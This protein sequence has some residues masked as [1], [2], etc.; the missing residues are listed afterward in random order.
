MIELKNITKKYNERTILD[1]ISLTIHPGQITFIVGT[2]GAGK[3]TLLNLIGGL[4][5][6]TSGD[7]LFNGTSIQKDLNT[8]RAKNIGFVFQDFN[9]FSQY[10]SLGGRL[11]YV[12]NGRVYTF[13]GSVFTYNALGVSALDAAYLALREFLRGVGLN[14]RDSV[15]EGFDREEFSSLLTDYYDAELRVNDNINK[16]I[17]RQIDDAKA[18]ILADIASFEGAIN[19]TIEEMQDVLDNTIETWF[20]SGVPSLST[21][22][23]SGWTS[24]EYEDHLGDLYY[25]DD[26]GNGY[27][28]QYDD[29]NQVYFWNLLQDT[30]ATAALALARQAKDTADGKRRVFLSQPTDAQAYDEGDLWLHATIGVYSDETLVCLTAKAAGVAFNAGDWTAATKYTDDTV[31]NAAQSAATAAQTT[32][33]NAATAASRAQTAADNAATAASTVSTRLDNWASDGYV[34]PTEKAALKQQKNE[35]DADYAEIIAD[36]TRYA[37][38]TT[39]FVSAYN[40]AVTA[41]NKYTAATPELIPVTAD[42]A[43]IAAYYTA[44]TTILE[45]IATAAKKV[46]TDA[47]AAADAAQTTATNAGSAA[48]AAQTTANNAASAAATA[49]S[50]ANAAKSIAEAARDKLATWGSD[51]YISPTEKTA[52]AQQY[53]D[54]QTERD[55]IVAQATSYSVST[56]SYLSAYTNAIAAFQKY[57]AASPESIAVDTDYADIAAYYDARTLIL[58]AISVAAKTVA[59]NAQ[60]AADNAAS[61]AREAKTAAEEVA[62]QL[63]KID[64]DAVLD[65]SE[66]EAIRTTWTSINGIVST[67]AMG[68]TGT[69]YAAKQMIESAAHTGFQVKYS[70]NNKI[71]TYRGAYDEDTQTY[72]RLI[73]TRNN[74]GEGALDAAYYALREYLASVQ[75]N[76]D[77]AFVGFDRSVYA[78][79]LRDYNVA[80]NNVMKVL[81]ELAQQTAEK[82]QDT[83][84]R[85]LVDATA[86]VEQLTAWGADGAIS[87]MEKR[88]LYQ[89]KADIEKEYLSLV[90]EAEDYGVSHS[91][92]D[93]AYTNA[94][95]ALTK[96]TAN[97][98]TDSA[99]DEDYNYIA[100]YFTARDTLVQAV[101][102][103]IKNLIDAKAASSDY[104]YLR[105]ALAKEDATVMTNGLVLSAFIGV[106]KNNSV[107]AAINASGDVAGFSDSTHGV[108]MIAAGISTLSTAK[109]TAAFRVFQDGYMVATSG[110][111]GGFNIGASAIYNGMTSYA[112]ITHDGV[113]VGTDG[114]ALG[115]GAITMH[116]SG[117]FRATNAIIEGKITATELN[118]TGATITGLDY[119]DVNNTPDLTVYVA[120]DGTIGSTPTEGSTGFVVSSAGLLKASNAIIYGTLYSSAGTIGGWTLASNRL[121]S[122]SAATYVG[123]S[124]S[125]S[126]TY[127]IWAGATTPASAPFSIT[128]AG[129]MKA[130]SGTIGGFD[131]SANSIGT[132]SDMLS[133]NQLSYLSN[134]YF[135]VT[136]CDI[137]N[138][139]INTRNV[140][141]D[142]R[143][144]G[145]TGTLISASST[146]TTDTL[147]KLNAASETSVAINCVRGVI[148][149]FRPEIAIKNSGVTLYNDSSQVILCNNT[150]TTTFTL[151]ST[152]YNGQMFAIVHLSTTQVNVAVT[153]THPIRRF[154]SG[155]STI[156]TSF[157]ST[158]QE[159]LLLQY[160]S[161]SSDTYNNTTRSGIWYLTYLKT[162]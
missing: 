124:S 9:L 161:Q 142:A 114:I 8:Y 74:I 152:P 123:L 130:T 98:T 6:P 149:G 82:A 138:T 70:F 56:A 7:I 162:T 26:T 12:Y 68:T 44:R 21:L 157:F 19:Q 135:N 58:N 3:T 14:D 47:Q 66:K 38:A 75:L 83:A 110:L 39:T 77:G 148:K 147:L 132:D 139:L 51:G 143:R 2:S 91:A 63:E 93:T 41:F 100:L 113:Y 101:D 53:K 76:I 158:T 37:V 112:D 141:L 78:D 127:A 129:V 89:L 146:Y 86:S 117:A 35:V 106:K 109:D 81:T 17:Q 24:A 133:N 52:L 96:Y 150:A 121:Y 65:Q 95:L 43:D 145:H 10:S 99:R 151:P 29:A 136:S 85:A 34:S 59:D 13:D 103:A 27:R 55:Q 64:L 102:T 72:E 97:L 54:V 118:L 131:I 105:T 116:P 25:D 134:G 31:A 154:V 11:K 94:I 36:A 122:G 16:A 69:Y 156:G 32:A 119:S 42:Y 40:A 61:L 48:A 45:A 57:T 20:Y 33:D 67:G 90:A 23:A 104:E 30:T 108:L 46:A 120:K 87:P 15:F 144:T 137:W 49:Q 73:Y 71:Y 22:P 79:R 28:F 60:T 18:E 160:S 84:D 126:D 155:S 4:H 153:A 115:K 111:I 5:N 80:L 50:T 128:R 159:V 92:Y 107:K 125:A 1:H 88:S 140:S 62:E